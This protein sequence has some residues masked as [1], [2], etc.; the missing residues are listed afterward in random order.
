M[1]NTKPA[2]AAL[3]ATRVEL[4]GLSGVYKAVSWSQDMILTSGGKQAEIRHTEYPGT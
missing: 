4:V 1:M 3:I 2:A